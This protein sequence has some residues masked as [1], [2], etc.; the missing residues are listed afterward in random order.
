MV[1]A[2]KEV[3]DT[4]KQISDYIYTNYNGTSNCC[5]KIAA[6]IQTLFGI[7]YTYSMVFYYV[8]KVKH[9][10]YKRSSY[11]FSRYELDLML[12][13]YDGTV[14]SVKKLE[15]LMP[16]RSFV[17]IY[18]KLT[19]LKLTKPRNEPTIWDECT[20]N[21]AYAI[22]C[23]SGIDEAVRLLKR[24]KYAIKHALYQNKLSLSMYDGFYL[25]NHVCEIFSMSYKYV[26]TLIREGK[27][28]ATREHDGGVW[29]IKINDL[30]AFIIRY[31]RELTDKKLDFVQV[32]TILGIGITSSPEKHFSEVCT[33][34][35]YE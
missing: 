9:P 17:A 12:K 11:D 7:H 35:N 20:V 3:I 21:K 14:T 26:L 5:T 4:D 27:L 24:S 34:E 6:D 29:R 16:Y 28:K 22:C 30:R 15:K 33:D 19:R 1:L 25:I 32:L 10:L 2:T 31:P 8:R 23:E 18:A 13:H